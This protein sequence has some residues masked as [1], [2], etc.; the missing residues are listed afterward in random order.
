ML[1]WI[2]YF[3]KFL[4]MNILISNELTGFMTDTMK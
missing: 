1:F 4:I 2:V 3:Y